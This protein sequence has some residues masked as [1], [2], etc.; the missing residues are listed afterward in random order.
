M[1]FN[2]VAFSIVIQALDLIM[3]LLIDIHLNTSRGG[4]AAHH[5]P[6]VDHWRK[7]ALDFVKLNS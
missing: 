6:N 3:G 2:K 1:E 5:R 7:K 4:P